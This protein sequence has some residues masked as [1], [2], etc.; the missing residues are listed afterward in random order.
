MFDPRREVGIGRFIDSEVFRT[1]EE[2]QVA[3]DLHAFGNASRP[4]DP[5]SLKNLIPDEKG[6][7]GPESPPLPMGPQHLAI[8]VIPG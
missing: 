6:I 4:R 8:Q 1:S 5:R 3:T 7:V 2:R